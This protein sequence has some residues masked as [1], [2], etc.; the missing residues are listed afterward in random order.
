MKPGDVVGVNGGDTGTTHWL[1]HSDLM[2][3]ITNNLIP[4]DIPFGFSD[5]GLV[6]ETRIITNRYLQYVKLLTP[7]GV[8]WAHQSWV[9]EFQR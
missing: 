2:D 3:P 9:K 7:R 1:Y 5:L 8:G 6:L 4:T